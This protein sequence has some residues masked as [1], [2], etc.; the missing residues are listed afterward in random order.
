VRRIAVL[1]VLLVAGTVCASV[2]ATTAPALTVRID[3]ALS[4]KRVTLSQTS[5]RR[6]YYAQFRVR[7][8]TAAHR[9]FT[10]AGR[11]IRVPARKVRL[12]VVDFLVR[13]RYPYASRGPQSVA[14]GVFR[15]N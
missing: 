9:I 7:N 8:R 12:V 5:I 13:G 6:G 10:I 15:V 1:T 11:S 4:V 3:V 2:S 14:R